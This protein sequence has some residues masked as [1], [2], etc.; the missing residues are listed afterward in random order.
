LEIKSNDSVEDAITCL[1][2]HNV[3][4]APV[5]DESA[6]NQNPLLD[7]YIGLVEFAGM[8]L[9]ALEKFKS[10]DSET[11]RTGLEISNNKS[12]F[13][14]RPSDNAE[15]TNPA[16]RIEE[17]EEEGFFSMLKHLPEVGLAKVGEIARSFRWGPFLPVRV[18]DSLLHVLLL[19][20]KHR[21][22]AVPVVNPPDMHVKGFI[23]QNAAVQILLQCSGLDWFDMIAHKAL[24][25]FGRFHKEQAFGQ[26]IHLYGNQFIIDAVDCL[27][28]HRIS[29]V[30]VIDWK[31]RTIL[32]HVRN[33]DMRLLLDD[34]NIFSKRRT[35]TIEEFMK[36]E[37]LESN[38]FSTDPVETDFAALLS[39]GILR[40]KNVSLPKMMNPPTSQTSDTLKM[41]MEKLVK[42]KSDRSFLINESQEL[43]GVFTLRDIIN[44]FSPPSLNSLNQYG[45]FFQSAL[46]Q[47]GSRMEGGTIV[48]TNQ[49]LS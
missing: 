18:D 36:L 9:W 25:D 20:S 8:V 45:G 6:S 28:K 49:L 34:H 1:Y 47:T 27:W 17:I 30:P 13:S 14:F 33:T 38:S 41:A 44:Q 35:L 26:I 42:A 21:L 32:G 5:L 19:L 2:K 29:A 4:G 10:A 40:L 12:N 31:S 22:K 46:E 15:Q 48:P 23:T 7:R 43:I 24:F 11:K 3:M 39:A 16:R 37:D